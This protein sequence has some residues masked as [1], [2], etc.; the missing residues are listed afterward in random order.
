MMTSVRFCRPNAFY[1][2]K[3][4]LSPVK[5]L[6]FSQL[7]NLGCVMPKEGVPAIGHLARNVTGVHA[8]KGD[9]LSTLALEQGWGRCQA[10]V[11]IGEHFPSS[12]S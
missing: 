11:R 7:T 4:P 10:Q 2:L 6:N 9:L 8:G 12:L 1:E 5:C 3:T